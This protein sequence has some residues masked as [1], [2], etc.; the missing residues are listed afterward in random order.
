MSAP[1]LDVMY[2]DIKILGDEHLPTERDG[3][4]HA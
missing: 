2:L 1:S 4:I 3:R